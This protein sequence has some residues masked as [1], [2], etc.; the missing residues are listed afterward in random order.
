MARLLFDSH[1]DLAWNTASF[2]R[3][4]TLPLELMCAEERSMSDRCFRGQA[5]VSFPEMRKTGIAVCIATLLARS[6]PEHVRQA[7][8]Q[9]GDLDFATRLG[10]HAAALG[11]LACYHYWESIGEIRL[12]KTQE[13]LQS[14][15]ALWKNRQGDEKLPIG[16]IL[17]ME[18]ADPVMSPDTLNR[19]WDW[20]LRAIEPAHYGRS[21]Y[22]SG[23]ATVGPLTEAGRELIDEMGRI[24]MALDVTHLC[25]ES[26]AEALDR[27]QGPV[28]ASHHN[29]RAL[30]PGDRQLTDEQIRQLIARDAV[31]GVAL[32]AW[33]L[34]PSWIRG[35]SDPST[36]SMQDVADHVDH[37]CQL[38]G[39]TRHSGIGSDLDGG[40]GTEQTPGDLKSIYDLRKL[41]EI[42]SG[43]GYTASDLDAIFYNNWLRKLIAALPTAG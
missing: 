4:L 8:Y 39:N 43:R 19:W 29:C 7:T 31:I 42:L 37:V 30:V 20:G 40:Y 33:M 5:T 26:M 35:K 6:G 15:D 24:G 13:D 3:D 16:V 28:W 41:E 25:D 23:T 9:R 36:V 12:L 22:A 27:Y 17:S 32:D 1:L 10:C 38:A 21:H 14:H 2:D 18:G 11:Q 34:S